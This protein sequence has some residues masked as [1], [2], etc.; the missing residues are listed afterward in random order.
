MIRQVLGIYTNV[1]EAKKS[2]EKEGL[3]IM[4]GVDNWQDWPWLVEK[5]FM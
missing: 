2:I 1:Y 4:I 3:K 5:V